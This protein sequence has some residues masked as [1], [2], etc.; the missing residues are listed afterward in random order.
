MKKEYLILIAIILAL[1][2]YLFLHKENK[3]NYTLPVT[4]TIEA[5]QISKIIL[6]SKNKTLEFKKK[7]DNWIINKEEYLA[8][9]SDIQNMIDTF[10]AFKLTA[11]VSEKGDKLRYE[12]DDAKRIDVNVFKGSQSIFKF[13]MGKTAPSFNHT[14]VMLKNDN[15]IYHAKGSFK[16]DFDKEMDDFRDK[17]VLEFK[18]ESIGQ[19]SVEK[20]GLVKTWSAQN[21]AAQEPGREKSPEDAP[22]IT[23]RSNDDSLVDPNAIADLLSSMAFLEC[24]K[25][26]YEITRDQL[27]AQIPLSVISLENPEKMM[28]KIF[29]KGAED[30]LIGISS[31]NDHV[32][33]LSSYGGHEK[34]IGK[35]SHIWFCLPSPGMYFC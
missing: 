30:Q 12:L 7:G 22:E 24:E 11:L 34:K 9:S 10:K 6:S 23:W 15:N 2:A 33:E 13:S 18:K 28:L 31:M 14:F 32:F 4:Q 8:S 16:S 26:S 20:D 27:D 1:G 35:N 25:Y 19:F 29:K 17:K 3:D 21:K 5:D